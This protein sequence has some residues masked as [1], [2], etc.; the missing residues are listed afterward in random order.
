MADT[1]NLTKFLG[2]VADAIRTKRETTDKIPAE[3]F[4][5]EILKIETGVNTSDATA[6]ATDIISPKTAYVNGEKI[7]GS[8]IPTYKVLE[9][10]TS[11]IGTSDTIGMKVIDFNYILHWT[12]TYMQMYKINES[13]VELLDTRTFA[14][15]GFSNLKLSGLVASNV[16]DD[17]DIR[18]LFHRSDKDGTLYYYAFD[19]STNL[20]KLVATNN[21][22]SSMYVNGGFNLGI[23]N[24]GKYVLSTIE[25]ASSDYGEMRFIVLSTTGFASANRFYYTKYG[26]AAS[27]IQ[28]LDNDTKMFVTIDSVQRQ[29]TISTTG[30]ITQVGSNSVNP[31]LIFNEDLSYGYESGSLYKINK[32][33]TFTA[34]DLIASDITLFIGFLSTDYIVYNAKIYE[35]SDI[36][37]EVYSSSYNICINSANNYNNMSFVDRVSASAENV[38]T[39]VNSLTGKVL[40]SLN[41]PDGL[42]SNVAN[43]TLTADKVLSGNKFINQ[44]GDDIGTLADYGA[45]LNTG[46]ESITPDTGYDGSYI[47]FKSPEQDGPFAFTSDKVRLMMTPQMSQVAEAIGL[48]SDK[49]I[50]G[51]TV[52]GIEGT[53]E[54]GGDT[55]DATATEKQILRGYTA[56][57]KTGKT[58]GTFYGAKL[59]TTVEEMNN[60]SDK[61][62]NDLALIYNDEPTYLSTGIL[63]NDFIFPETITLDHTYSSEDN[64]MVIIRSLDEELMLH[65][66]LQESSCYCMG[67]FPEGQVWCDYSSSDGYTYTRNNFD[68]DTSY[69]TIEGNVLSFT[70]SMKIDESYIDNGDYTNANKFLLIS[71][72][73]MYGLYQAKPVDN[74][75]SIEVLRGYTSLSKED[76]IYDGVKSY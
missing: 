48:T 47:E 42:L 9:N 41:T 59:F 26:H 5:S 31:N 8:L 43:I 4:D 22:N 7:E 34:G 24:N 25:Q 61:Q 71:E 52:L 10:I 2:D 75:D 55:S 73:Q 18:I 19:I 36:L 30:T 14:D 44:N 40:Q 49:L 63:A 66:E 21:Y 76:M 65:V 72:H 50:K 46:I 68:I 1:S 54:A 69:A 16:T 67:Y 53:A 74:P 29:Y 32:G 12:S 20:F 13:S 33:T 39:N 6:L 62:E 23:S 70:K 11:N 45:G 17:N 64:N 28:F 56:Y 51:N 57:T 58:T 60:D 3:S 37:S 38:I 15:D 27:G 35:I